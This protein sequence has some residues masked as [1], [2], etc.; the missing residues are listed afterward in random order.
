MQHVINAECY[1]DVLFLRQFT[2]VLKNY[3]YKITSCK[4]ALKSLANS[5]T[6]LSKGNSAV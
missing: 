2:G 5:S 1:K 6:Q 3:T 4:A